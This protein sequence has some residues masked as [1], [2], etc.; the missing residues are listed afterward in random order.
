M[1]TLLPAWTTG[2]IISR[3]CSS[4][5]FEVAACCPVLTECCCT[6]LTASRRPTGPFRSGP[7][8][9]ES[10]RRTI[11]FYA[12]GISHNRNLGNWPPRTCLLCFLFTGS[13][14]DKPPGP[15]NSGRKGE[16]SSVE[17]LQECERSLV[18]KVF[19]FNASRFAP[20]GSNQSPYLCRAK[21]TSDVLLAGSLDDK[22]LE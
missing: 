16:W 9:S 2:R 13:V 11:Y 3:S 14:T 8:V 20:V 1:K 17:V 12:Q 18:Q 4:A 5:R 7:V 21:Y 22:S 15:P 19:F 6:G 10:S